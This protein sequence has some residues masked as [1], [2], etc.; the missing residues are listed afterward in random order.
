MKYCVP[1]LMRNDNPLD[2]D[3]QVAV[4]GNR[5]YPLALKIEPLDGVGVCSERLIEQFDTHICAQAKRIRLT[6][7]SLQRLNCLAHICV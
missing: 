7:L 3:R 2:N 6:V 1:Q 4:D 5:A